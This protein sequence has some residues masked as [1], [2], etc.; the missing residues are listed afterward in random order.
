MSTSKKRTHGSRTESIRKITKTGDY[1]F[2]VTIPKAD[3]DALGWRER[4][5]V[6]VK[7]V[8]HGH[9]QLGCIV[10]TDVPQE[11]LSSRERQFMA[12]I[13]WLGPFVRPL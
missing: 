6:V 13:P 10:S 1:T 9:A 3:L 11:A 5:K 4:Q 7:R 12:P 2:Y 8:G